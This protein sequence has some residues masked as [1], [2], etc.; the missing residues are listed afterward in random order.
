MSRVCVRH[1]FQH[2]VVY[3]DLKPEN[4]LMDEFGRTKLS[5]LGDKYAN[6]LESLML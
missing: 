3:R 2:H 4:I 6:I 5:D 1:C